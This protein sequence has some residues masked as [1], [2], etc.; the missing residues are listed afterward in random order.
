[1]KLFF[2]KPIF[3]FSMLVETRLFFS[4]PMLQYMLLQVRGKIVV[5]NYE[6]VNYGVSGRY[7]IFGAQRAAAVGAV[8]TLIRSATPFSINSPHTGWQVMDPE[9]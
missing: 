9:N 8:A 7:R 1:M 4:G 3:I 5:F 6:W 2:Q